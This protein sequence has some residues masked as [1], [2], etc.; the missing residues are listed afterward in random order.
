MF[1]VHTARMMNVGIDLTDVVKVPR[2]RIIYK[3]AHNAV[4]GIK[5]P[6]RDFLLKLL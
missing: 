3:I 1:L 6:V 2:T 4:E 5:V